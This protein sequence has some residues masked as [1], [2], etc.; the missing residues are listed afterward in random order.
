MVQMLMVSGGESIGALRAG[1]DE[2]IA[3]SDRHAIAHTMSKRRCLPL[4]L[5][6]HVEA[7]GFRIADGDLAD[8]TGK[9]ESVRNGDRPTAI[10][11]RVTPDSN[12]AKEQGHT[13]STRTT[14]A[15]RFFEAE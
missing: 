10:R 4:I 7:A 13:M 15:G 2:I 12:T 9:L 1:A 6:Q 11:L 14:P 8:V 5:R 3:E